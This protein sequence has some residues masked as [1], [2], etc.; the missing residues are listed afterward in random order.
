MSPIVLIDD[1][2]GNPNGDAHIRFVHASPD[3]PTVNIRVANGG[4]TLFENVTFRGIADYIGVGSATY[5]LEVV[6]TSNG[7]VA[8]TVPAVVLNSST[9][10]TI[11]AIGLAGNG[12][13]A[14]L[15][16]VDSA[17]N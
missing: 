8:L 5:D 6:L 14:A 2:S 3:A 1:R 13:L 10:Y 9:N 11:F 17:S 15:P 7:D 4:P 16:V 12:T